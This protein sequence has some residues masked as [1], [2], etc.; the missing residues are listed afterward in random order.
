MLVV[1]LVGEGD[2]VRNIIFT[3]FVIVALAASFVG[4]NP[5]GVNAQ[6]NTPPATPAAVD[7]CGDTDSPSATI[8]PPA[9]SVKEGVVTPLG[10][11][12]QSLWLVVVTLPKDEVSCIS[13]R[14]RDAGVVIFVQ[15]GTITYTAHFT[16]NPGVKEVL[17]GN[18]D[19]SDADTVEVMPDT[20]TTVSANEWI[21]Q[22]RALWY[23]FVNE[24][25]E[26]AVVSIASYGIPPWDMDPCSS[27]CRKP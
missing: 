12:N 9:D 15:K 18:S 27:G 8:V 2:V 4:S 13:Y 10:S 17:K 20:P 21:S 25:S 24:G 26:E 6:G 1:D 7:N 19:G 11:N 16:D 14:Y 23:T 3:A 22:D 5:L